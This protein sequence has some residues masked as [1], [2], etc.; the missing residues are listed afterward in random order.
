ML[1]QC[2]G[3]CTVSLCSQTV[4]VV[5][6]DPQL[7]VV[8]V[9]VGGLL[10]GIVCQ[11]IGRSGS[12]ALLFFQQ[13]ERQLVES[14][15]DIDL[16]GVMCPR[17]VLAGFQLGHIGE[18]ICGAAIGLTAEPVRA[19]VCFYAIEPNEPGA[20]LKADRGD[21]AGRERGCG[22]GCIGADAALCC[23]N[24]VCAADIAHLDFQ[25]LAQF[26]S[27]WGGIHKFGSEILCSLHIDAVG[28]RRGIGIRGVEDILGFFLIG[29]VALIVQQ[30]H[31]VR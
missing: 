8:V 3:R 16:V 24:R 20:A 4:R 25:A 2:L 9:P 6:H 26:R 14:A 23:D 19:A 29:R 1:C 28:R 17:R 5:L 21:F 22:L 15:P 7:G 13:T 27:V 12:A 11:A 18:R 31:T 30:R 10:C